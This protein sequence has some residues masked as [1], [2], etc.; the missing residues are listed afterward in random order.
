[1]FIALAGAVAV[2]GLVFVMPIAAIRDASRHSDAVWAG[3]GM[4][5]KSWVAAMA[6]GPIFFI[7][8]VS[9]I[10]IAASGI[11]W[12][13]RR[14]RLLASSASMSARFTR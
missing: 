8:F 2:I 11:Y 4:S 12:A 10:G 6:C 5:K 7:P 1:M 3:A 13:G 9:L 14:K